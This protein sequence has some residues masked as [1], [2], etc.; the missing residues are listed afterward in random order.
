MVDVSRIILSHDDAASRTSKRTHSRSRSAGAPS[1]RSE[2]PSTTFVRGGFDRRSRWKRIH[3]GRQV[4]GT[5]S[6]K[7]RT[8]DWIAPD[9]R[10]RHDSNREASEIVCSISGD[11]LRLDWRSTAAE[12]RERREHPRTTRRKHPII[13]PTPSV[14][15]AKVP[16][17]PA[18]RKRVRPAVV[19][20]WVIGTFLLVLLWF[21]FTS[22]SVRLVVEP[23]PDEIDLPT[24]LFGFHI[25]E[26]YLLRPGSHEVVA[27]RKRVTT[28]WR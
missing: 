21:S 12:C 6:R 17:P 27:S 24:A 7:W 8:P 19:A 14:P 9:R 20:T 13:P 18:L 25:G 4:D 26:R 2:F 23:V 22:V 16:Q 15:P 10:W 28:R 3:S 1:T 11:T 5:R